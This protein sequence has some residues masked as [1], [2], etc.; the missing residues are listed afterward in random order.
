MAFE[1]TDGLN[2][3]SENGDIAFGWV[4]NKNNGRNISYPIGNYSV[5]LT[6]QNQ[7][8]GNPVGAIGDFSFATGIDT[9][10]SGNSSSA[11]GERTTASGRD[12][13]AIGLDT[14]ASGDYTFA[15]G[16]ESEA[17]GLQSVAGGFGAIASGVTSFAFGDGSTASGSD[18]VAIGRGLKSQNPNSVTLGRFNTGNRTDTIFEIGAG[19]SDTTRVNIFEAYVNATPRNMRGALVAPMLDHAT[20]RNSPTNRIL[21]TKEYM[22]EYGGSGGSG[23]TIIFKG[24]TTPSNAL[25]TDGDVYTYYGITHAGKFDG[26]VDLVDGLVPNTGTDETDKFDGNG[27]LSSHTYQRYVKTNASWEQINYGISDAPIDNK[28]YARS[29]ADWVEVQASGGGTSTGLEAIDEGQGIGWRLIG[30]NPDNYGDIGMFAVDLSLGNGDTN[31]ATGGVAFAT[32]Y[33]TRAIGDLS[34]AMGYGTVANGQS[35]TSMGEGTVASGQGAIS[36]GYNAEADGDYSVATG[37]ST[38]ASGGASFAMGYNTQSSGNAS[39][40]MGYATDYGT[41]QSTNDGT[42]AGGYA[43]NYSSGSGSGSGLLEFSDGTIASTGKGSFAFGYANELLM[44]TGKGT[45]AMG[46]NAKAQNT[47]SVAIGYNTNALSDGSVALGYGT[48]SANVGM[49]AVGQYN[50]STIGT[51]FEVG[52]GS[53][54]ASRNNAFEIYLNGA[55]IAPS[56]EMND[57]VE[58]KSLI[59]KEYLEANSG[60]SV[61]IDQQLRYTS[62]TN[63]QYDVITNDLLV[64]EF[65]IGNRQL[66]TY[67][68]GNLNNIEY[69]DVDGITVL[70][71]VTYGYDVNG[72]LVTVTRT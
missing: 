11:S 66:Y 10:A 14:I 71:T 1:P 30:A 2:Y 16:R 72:N 23:D 62:V 37:N 25:G 4:L 29:N 15:Y 57:I 36:A 61:P 3:I 12:S 44:A 26:N 49:C 48:Y 60:G 32:G 22:D 39:F 20:I 8:Y 27:D 58:P 70:L 47:G 46:I 7:A 69:T 21:I 65:V 34:T 35:S 63:M 59:T 6:W 38:T 54:N 68:N 9:L 5:D 13:T 18:S 45:V 52:N 43:N 17:Q 19:N 24:T 67:T 56:L 41:I 42:F 64:M 28:Q 51:I 31:G 50:A 40:A 33:A 53:N 55:V